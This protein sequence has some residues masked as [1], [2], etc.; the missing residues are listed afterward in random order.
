[1]GCS[2]S[3]SPHDPLVVFGCLLAPVIVP[4]VIIFSLIG[5]LFSLPLAPIRQRRFL[6]QLETKGRMMRWSDVVA[7]LERD[8]GTLIIDLGAKEPLRAW[9]TTDD[10]R[11]PFGTRLP[12]H[13]QDPFKKLLCN[14]T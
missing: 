2:E 14:F 8:E 12:Q 11:E 9:W 4:A 13:V 1:M 10:L 6:R 5:G 3:R 7:S